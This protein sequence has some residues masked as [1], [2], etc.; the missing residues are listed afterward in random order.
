METSNSSP[1]SLQRVPSGIIAAVRARFAPGQVH[2][3]CR[4][5]LGQVHAAR[6]SGIQLD[7]QSIF[8]YREAVDAPGQLDV[9]FGVGVTAPPQGH[10]TAPHVSAWTDPAN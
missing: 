3:E 2:V 5:H 9:E 8:V 1:V 6:G 7:G 4:R 10:P